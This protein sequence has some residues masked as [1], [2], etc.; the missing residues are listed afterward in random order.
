MRVI[1]LPSDEIAREVAQRIARLIRT[2]S[3]SGRKTVLGLATGVTPLGVYAE[4]VRLHLEEGLDYSGVVTFN[5]DEYFPIDRSDPRSYHRYMEEHLFRHLNLD[6]SNV[7]L[8]DGR[9]GEPSARGPDYEDAIEA[10]GGVDLQLLGIGKNGHIGFNEPGSGPASRTRRVTLAP[11]T[12]ANVAAQFGGLE[13]VPLEAITA[14]VGTIL[15]AREIIVIATGEHKAAVVA[16]T[17]EGAITEE[18]PATFLQRHPHTTLFV[19]AAAA[20]LL[21]DPSRAQGS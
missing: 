13:K 4:L 2:R 19:D 7:H 8:P 6:P 12:R 10:A 1:E 21:S 18:V 9:P 20:A 11:L 16:R 5:L 15:A 3:S 17:V 14:G